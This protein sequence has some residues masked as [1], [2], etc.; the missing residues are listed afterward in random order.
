MLSFHQ[1]WFWV[2]VVVNGLV[3]LWGL[4]FAVARRDPGRS[5]L[6]AR[7]V[8][9]T[10][11]LVQIGAGLVLWQQGRRPG[12]GFHVFYGIVIVFTFTFAY[13]YRPQLEKRP[14]LGYGLLLLFVMG[15]GLRAWANVF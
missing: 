12:N 14:A 15:L 3:G 9:I 5:F 6:W 7:G 13:I 4:G 11:M 8:A 2:A 10:A 1:S